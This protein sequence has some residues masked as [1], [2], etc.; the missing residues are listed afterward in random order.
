MQGN[1]AS[2]IYNVAELFKS[3][4]NFMGMLGNMVPELF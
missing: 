4:R 1:M 3:G 2:R